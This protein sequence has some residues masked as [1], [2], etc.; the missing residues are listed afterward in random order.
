MNCRSLRSHY[1]CS[2]RA[3]AYLNLSA[4][5]RFLVTKKD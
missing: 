5:G 2:I 3:P 4:F 1:S